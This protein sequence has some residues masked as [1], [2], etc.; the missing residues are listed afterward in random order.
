MLLAIDV[1]NS[2][3]LCGLYE[4]G[5]PHLLASFRLS[6]DR[7]RTADE[8]LAM[9]AALVD[10]DGRRLRDVDAVI[11]SSVVPSVTTWLTEMCRRGLGLDPI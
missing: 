6:T 7:D 5:G 9:L 2:N 8:W 10:H 1:G 3:I 11:L 4:S